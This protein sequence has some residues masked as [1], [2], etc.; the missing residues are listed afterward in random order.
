[1]PSQAERGVY[2]KA[3]KVRD[4]NIYNPF[5]YRVTPFP[6]EKVCSFCESKK[7]MIFPIGPKLCGKCTE[8]ILGRTD[9]LR[10]TKGKMDLSGYRCDWCGT[11]TFFPTIV[12]TRICNGC[13]KK[14]ARQTQ[15]NMTKL[16]ARRV[17]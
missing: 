16:G 2:G 15:L 17:I 7:D 5:G 8:R 14:L 13:T 9:V 6:T 1:M 4:W 11:V 10:N 3:N 12:N